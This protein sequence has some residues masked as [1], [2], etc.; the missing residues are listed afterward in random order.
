M[1]M[2]ASITEYS[3]AERMQNRLDPLSARTLKTAL[4]IQ[5]LL[6]DEE[7]W[8]DE[9]DEDTFYDMCSVA[10]AHF[11]ARIRPPV[12]FAV[13]PMLRPWEELQPHV[14]R[15][16]CRFLPHDFLRICD[17][18]RIPVNDEGYHVTPNR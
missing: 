11:C 2:T 5:F 14:F 8:C 13:P 7:D 17:T 1:G 12:E 9:D 16:Q 4:Q 6:C 10:H 18:I 3:I 15:E